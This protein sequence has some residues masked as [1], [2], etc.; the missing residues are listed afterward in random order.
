MASMIHHMCDESDLEFETIVERVVVDDP[1]YEG[2]FI[3]D[4]RKKG[5]KIVIYV[6]DYVLGD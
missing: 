4:V 5:N 6:Y 3:N 1:F 2:A